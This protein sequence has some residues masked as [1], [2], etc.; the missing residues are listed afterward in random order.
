MIGR[1][2]REPRTDRPTRGVVMA[3][4]MLYFS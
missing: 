2:L 1:P 4:P 3:T